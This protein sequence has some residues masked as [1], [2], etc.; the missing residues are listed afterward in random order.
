MTDWPA[1]SPPTVWRRGSP[2][3]RAKKLRS[4][5]ELPS[6]MA[7]ELSREL[8]RAIILGNY[9]PGVRFVEEDIAAAF[10]ISRSPVREAFR[11]LEADGLVVRSERRGVRVTPISIADLDELYA[12][13]L[14]LEGLAAEQ[15]KAGGPAARQDLEAALTLLGEARRSGDMMKYFEANIAL[16][17]RI[18]VLTGNR[19]L[20]RLLQ[21]LTKQSQRYRFLA[22]NRFPKMIDYSLQANR[23]LVAA[24]VAG[25]GG[26]A[27]DI[28][29]LLVR[30]AW[31]KIREAL[32]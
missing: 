30:H 12:C 15:A 27:R 14:E 32:K 4:D 10:K 29:R 5:V 11:R 24:I 21:G 2:T 31:V 20:I 26:Y 9:E 6:L 1:G 16:T 19:T 7:T 18:H 17:E 8:E 13:R 28:A 22:Y 25:E 3:T 23:D